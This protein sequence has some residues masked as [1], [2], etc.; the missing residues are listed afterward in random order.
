MPRYFFHLCRDGDRLVDH[1]GQSLRDADQAWETAK[2]VAL[3]LMSGAPPENASW[4]SYHFEVTS[5]AG[6]VLLEL[7]FAEVRGVK[8]QPS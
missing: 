6:E 1:D 4:S 3:D 8:S 7:P 2:S 5:E